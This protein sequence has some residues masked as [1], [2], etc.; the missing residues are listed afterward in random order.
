MSESIYDTISTD[1][2]YER[3]Y[4]VRWD[5]KGDDYHVDERQTA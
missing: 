4:T 2:D 1:D 3:W 5:A